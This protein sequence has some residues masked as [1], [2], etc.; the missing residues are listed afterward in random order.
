[1]F[2]GKIPEKGQI[3]Q[4]NAENKTNSQK[5]DK[6][7]C[8]GCRY[9]GTGFICYNEREDKCLRDWRKQIMKQIK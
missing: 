5:P 8:D 1:L 6:H 4:Q 9:K 2:A 3:M 7:K